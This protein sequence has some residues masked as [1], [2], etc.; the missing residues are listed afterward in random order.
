M[1]VVDVHLQVLGQLVDASGEDGDL[2]LR[3]A[4][5]GLVGAVGFDNSSLFV[6]ADHGLVPPFFV[7]PLTE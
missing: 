5:V 4:G 7:L 6:L 3:R 2:D 1:V